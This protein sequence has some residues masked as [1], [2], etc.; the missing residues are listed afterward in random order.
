MKT[1]QARTTEKLTATKMAEIILTIERIGPT[2]VMVNA[3]GVCVDSNKALRSYGVVPDAIF[4]RE[5]GWSLGAPLRLAAKAKAAWRGRWV[6]M[7]RV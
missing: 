7:Y 3:R 5:D 1:T 6:L 4:V 2:R